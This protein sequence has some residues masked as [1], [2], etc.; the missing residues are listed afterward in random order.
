MLPAFLLSLLVQ[1]SFAQSH[2]FSGLL[3]TYRQTKGFSGAVLVASGGRVVYTG[4]VGRADRQADVPINTRS[5]FKI[6]SVTKAFT[7]VLV[8]KLV[9]DGKIQLDETIGAYYPNYKGA[10]KDKVTLHHL[11]TY[12]SGIKHELEPLGM[13]PYQSELSLDDFIAAYCSGPLVLT[14]GTQSVY[15]NTEYII[16]QKIIELV[17]GK[18]YDAYL[19]EVILEPLA[20]KRTGLVQ[21]GRTI[22]GLVTTYT[23]NDS[24]KTFAADVP[25]RAENYFAAGAAYSTL[26]DLFTFSRALFEH[27]ILKAATLAKMLAINDRLGSTAYGFW[28]RVAGALLKNRSITVQ[29]AF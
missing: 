5:A 19:R 27:R 8:M 29:E 3:E 17:A 1:L 23:Y 4:A 14:P 12:S 2:S 26:E 13:R 28:G 24:L 11:L 9:E 22:D 25:Y 7:A 16:L 15:G 21:T 20:L 6:A 18:P 10:A